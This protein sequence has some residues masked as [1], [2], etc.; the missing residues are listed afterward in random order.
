[1]N[2]SILV[3]AQHPEGLLS[4]AQAIRKMGY[5]VLTALPTP[6][7]LDRVEADAPGVVLVRPSQKRAEQIRCLEEMRKRFREQG[8]PVVV[9]GLTDDEVLHVREILPGAPVVVGDPLRLNGIQSLLQK[10]L[11]FVTRSELRVTVERVTAYRRSDRPGDLF[12]RY[13]P[14]MSLSM[15]GCFIRTRTPYPIGAQVEL[16]FYPGGESP[17][18]RLR[19]TVRWHGDGKAADTQGMGILFDQLPRETQKIVESVLKGELGTPDFPADL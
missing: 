5:A 16:L 13:D 11:N 8:I 12:Y 1:M 4:L 10:M 19:G 7:E 6:E 3:V 9:C 2:N 15:R 14:M 18:I 17:Y